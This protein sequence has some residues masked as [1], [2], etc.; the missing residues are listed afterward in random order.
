MLC[1]IHTWMNK[2]FPDTFLCFLRRSKCKNR[3]V[4]LWVVSTV[5]SESDFIGISVDPI[6]TGLPHFH[7]VSEW[8]IVFCGQWR[9][10]EASLGVQA[11]L[12]MKEIEEIINGPLHKTGEQA[13][14]SVVAELLFQTFSKIQTCLRIIYSD[15]LN[16][17]YCAPNSK[18]FRF[19]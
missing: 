15:T 10:K 11:I 13:V 6:Q 17:S 9:R 19:H 18:S 3:I 16:R 1:G 2:C 12:W 8:G 4:L 5:V 14:S 7:W